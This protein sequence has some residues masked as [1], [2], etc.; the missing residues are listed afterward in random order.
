MEFINLG[1]KRFRSISTFLFQFSFPVLRIFCFC[2]PVNGLYFRLWSSRDVSPLNGHMMAF[3]I[4]FVDV[5]ELLQ[6]CVM[7]DCTSYTLVMEMKSYCLDFQ[8]FWSFA[9]RSV[10]GLFFPLRLL[11]NICEVYNKTVRML[12]LWV[13]CEYGEQTDEQCV[14]VL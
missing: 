2:S 5:S 13:G 8:G 12:Q 3:I 4:V 11:E 9:C 7:I 6:L 1:G 14:C 10:G